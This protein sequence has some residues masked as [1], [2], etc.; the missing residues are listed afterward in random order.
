MSLTAACASHNGLKIFRPVPSVQM[1]ARKS[2]YRKHLY[3]IDDDSSVRSALSRSL[4]HL[5]YDV[6][7][8]EGAHAFFEK[9]VLFRPAVLLVDMQMPGVN[10]AQLQAS[11]RERGW[12]VPVIF[13]S[14]E[15]TVQQAITAMKQGA[16]DFLVKPFDLDRLERAVD[17]AIELEVRQMWGLSRQEECRQRLEALKP[18][19][20]DAYLCLAKGHGY[21]EMMR[22]LGISLP[23]AKQYR[24]AVMRKL[25]FATLAEL[26]AFDKEL[27]WAEPELGERPQQL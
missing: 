4:L 11:L 2:L 14:G 22:A 20:F 26:L 3:I 10:G 7:H 18:R 17:S 25:K 12:R 24:T 27:N 19:E 8:F 6:Q 16:L 23:T 5:G 15:S 13:I 21:G 1:T 9:A